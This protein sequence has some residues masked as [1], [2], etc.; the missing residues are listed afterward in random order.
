MHPVAPQVPEFAHVATATA[1]ADFGGAARA[2]LEH[3]W[4]RTG[5]GLWMVTRLEGDDLV[6]LAALDRGYGVA[7]GD[8]LRFADTFCSAMVAGRGPRVAPRVSAEAAYRDLP[9]AA[10]MPVAAYVGVPLVRPDGQLLGTLCGLD[11]SPQPASLA[12]ELASLELVGRLLAGLLVSELD[13][14]AE[15]RQAAHATAAGLDRLTKAANRP[16]WRLLLR[17]EEERCRRYGS[18]A[19]VLVVGLDDLADSAAVAERA[20]AVLGRAVEC[21]VRHGG[22]GDLVARTEPG[23]FAV[24][25]VEC[26]AAEAAR[27]AATCREALRAR[28]VEASVGAAA[29]TAAGLEEAWER[30]GAAMR[31]EQQ[32]KAAEAAPEAPPGRGPAYSSTFG[33]RCWGR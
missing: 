32:A 26:G 23:G 27:R 28:G 21:L 10:R 25:A 30:A 20:E 24:L 14:S 4:A 33:G 29:R 2:V 9:V 19:A 16:A 13:R 6:V 12:A 22:E 11:P 8:R 31:E 18:P 7:P 3:L 17:R 15:A 1:P 5:L